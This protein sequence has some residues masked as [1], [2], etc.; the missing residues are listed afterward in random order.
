MPPISSGQ[1]LGSAGRHPAIGASTCCGG[2]SRS[3]PSSRSFRCGSHSTQSGASPER[4]MRKPTTTRK[5][6]TSSSSSSPSSTTTKFSPEL[7]LDPADAGGW[8]ELRLLGHRMVDE[9]LEYL[10]TVRERPVWRPVPADVRERLSGA[11]PREPTPVGDVY[12]QFKRDVLPYP[13][14]NIHP[15]FW[16]WV[17]GTG[18]P[19][20][21]L[22]DM[23]ASGMN[24][25]VAEFD[26]SSAVVENQV[27]GW[28]VELLGL[29]AGTHGLLVS[30]GSMANFVGLAVARNA[31][32]GFDVRERGLQ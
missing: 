3:A 6:A 12:E 10:R 13:T 7:S 2:S 20:A 32:A 22:A 23:L 30:G 25:Q 17:I 28:L 19:V 8:E 29:P 21:M 11:A 4:I 15:R 18:T 5:T 27:I 16:G 26:D 24:P 9:M 31:R 14:G 1:A